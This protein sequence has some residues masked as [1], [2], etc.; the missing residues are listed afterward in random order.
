MWLKKFC[1]HS[2]KFFCDVDVSE[3]EEP[4]NDNTLECVDEDFFHFDVEDSLF[5]GLPDDFYIVEDSLL[6][7][8]PGEEELDSDLE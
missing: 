8:G 4:E 5:A 1:L 2:I 7:H 6:Q 3:S